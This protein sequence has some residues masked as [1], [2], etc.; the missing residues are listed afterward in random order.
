MIGLSR[1]SIR[2]A[3]VLALAGV[4]PLDQAAAQ[5]KT[6]STQAEE[7]WLSACG[8]ILRDYKWVLPNPTS[9]PLIG[10]A[11]HPNMSGEKTGRPGPSPLATIDELLLW[12]INRR[13]YIL[14][15]E[16]HDNPDHHAIQ[17][18]FLNASRCMSK[19]APN[20]AVFEHIRIDQSSALAGAS[21]PADMAASDLLR[22]LDWPNSGWPDQSMFQPLF[23]AAY[24]GGLTILPGEPARG[25]VRQVAR[26][27]LRALPEPDRLRLGLD[28]D[29]PAE[30]S[31]ALVRELVASHCNMLPASAISGLAQAQRYRDAHLA[32]AMLTAAARHD[33]VF[34]LA[35]N[36]HVRSDRGVP[37]QLRNRNADPASVLTI[38]LIEVE[39]SRHDAH[40]YV[41]HGPGGSPAADILIFTPRVARPD[42]CEQMRAMKLAK[43]NP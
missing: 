42:P 21:E 36:G 18:A 27:G 39:D 7:S 25:S 23:A 32:D 31:D 41:P 43:P 14:I 34:L 15:G 22:R 29:L 13:K 12:D 10:R 11:S 33:K 2:A 5:S 30:S 1:I 3:L 4:A 20:A 19:S 17:A 37:W 8:P 26:E 16:V 38:M 6:Q 40:T 35:G 9:H 24:A 28:R